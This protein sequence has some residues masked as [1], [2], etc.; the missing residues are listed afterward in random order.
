MFK[1]STIEDV[2]SVYSGLHKANPSVNIDVVYNPTD[3]DYTLSLTDKPFTGH[4]QIPL[5]I[6]TRVIYGDTDSIFVQFKF[7]RADHELNRYD[8]FKLSSVCSDNLTREV[9]NRGP[10]EMEFEKVFQPFVLITKKRYVGKK[11]DDLKNPLRLKEITSAGI[12]ITRR[13]Y[14]ELTKDCL[15]KIIDE[16]VNNQDLDAAERVYMDTL[17]DIET[18][19]VNIDQ[20][21]VTC[22]LNR[23][24][25]TE[26]VHV[27]LARKLKE[28]KCQVQIG[29]RI[30]YI[31][32]EGEK[33][34]KKSLLGEDPDYAKEHNLKFNRSCYM[35]QLAKPILGFLK[36]AMKD[37]PSR[38]ER[39]VQFTQS[40]LAK[41]NG[42]KLKASDF[43]F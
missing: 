1:A 42:A 10:I 19:S 36:V 2:E 11:Y 22:Q 38:T 37:D 27:V 3:K 21:V 20:L 8:T 6:E 26:P 14:C 24:Y 43:V 35:E 23:E 16:I 5:C 32:I 9:F 7:N 34:V 39:L 40:K 25:K 12:A 31:F 30:P 4:P 29:D 41:V 18:Y 28:R 15:R 33:G 13:D 17:E